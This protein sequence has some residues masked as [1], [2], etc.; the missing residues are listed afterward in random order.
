MA[1]KRHEITVDTLL[2]DLETD[3][4]LAHT[5]LQSGAAVSATMAKARL[6]GLIVDRTERG[7]P[8]DFA[9]LQSAAE[10]IAAVRRDLGDEVANALAELVDRDP[11]EPTHEAP[12][13]RQ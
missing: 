4:Q 9:N 10:V 12:S 11:P 8:G 1:Q 13:G 3:R 5:S 2:A 7:A 6:L